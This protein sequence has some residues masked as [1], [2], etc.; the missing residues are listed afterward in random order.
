MMASLTSDQIPISSYSTA[1]TKLYQNVSADVQSSYFAALIAAQRFFW[2]S[3]IFL[4]AAALMVRF[5]GAAGAATLVSAA[6]G[7][8]GVPRFAAQN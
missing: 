3:A 4:R 5:F 1:T 2:A 6:T 8:F 7:F